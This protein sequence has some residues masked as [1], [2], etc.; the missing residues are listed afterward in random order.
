[1]RVSQS[2]RL[3]RMAR[4]WRAF[5]SSKY[6]ETI[7]SEDARMDA[8]IS[9][10]VMN[11]KQVAGSPRGIDV[12]LE[13]PRWKVIVEHVFLCWRETWPCSDTVAGRVKNQ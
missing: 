2:E 8:V 6:L 4:S 13:M 9:E 11:M 10:R 12:S 5:K 1:M 3:D 7:H